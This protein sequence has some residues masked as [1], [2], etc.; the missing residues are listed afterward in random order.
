MKGTQKYVGLTCGGTTPDDRLGAVLFPLIYM[1]SCRHDQASPIILYY[2]A[3]PSR[4]V[5]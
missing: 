4:T 3:L 1:P 2:Y 5:S